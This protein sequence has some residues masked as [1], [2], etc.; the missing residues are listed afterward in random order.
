[1]V[2]SRRF[3]LSSSAAV[4]LFTIA[5]APAQAGA[6]ER[7]NCVGEIFSNTLAPGTKDD[8]VAFIREA[9]GTGGP[10]VVIGPAARFSFCQAID[11]AG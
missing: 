5:A 2:L 4:L 6:S 3:W 9:V 8:H 11:P 10:G 1:M 7:A